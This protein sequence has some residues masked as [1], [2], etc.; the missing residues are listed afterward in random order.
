MQIRN[1]NWQTGGLGEIGKPGHIQILTELCR[2]IP[3]EMLFYARADTH[4]LLHIYDKMKNELIDKTNPEMP[5]ENRIDTVLQKSKEISLLRYERQ[6]YHADTGKGPGGWYTLLMKTPS[7]FNNEQFSVFRAVHEWRDEIA[8]IDDDSTSFVMPN[9]VIF[10][11]AKL[12]PNDMVALLGIAHPISHSVKSRTGE[13][14][15]LIKSA[16][17]SGKDGPSMMDILRPDSV[18]AVAKAKVTSFTEKNAALVAVVDETQLRSDES[19][20]W[21]SAFGSSIWDAPTAK[22]EDMRLAVL[23]PALSS[24]IF[25]APQFVASDTNNALTDRSR[26][27]TQTPSQPAS[28]KAN[29]EEAFILKRGDKR[30][31]DAISETEE[32]RGD[33]DVSLPKNE[34]VLEVGAERHQQRA[35]PKELAEKAP[36]EEKRARKARREEK[37]K[38]AGTEDMDEEPFDY[39]KAESVL[40]GKSNGEDGQSGKKAKKTFDP[41]VKS[42]DAPTGMRRLQTERPGKSHTFKS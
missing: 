5:G 32:I 9:H 14:L 24:E 23:L 39:S 36:K 13:L 27:Q 35:E 42:A 26:L 38:A 7:L 34:V 28:P 19:S 30:K 10:K 25:E 20:F 1:I 6:I 15:D 29:L 33:S 4:F 41:Y 16:K 3:E 8:R 40:H 37:E 2:P 31:S 12:L 18:G 21:G 22:S 11:I 17:A